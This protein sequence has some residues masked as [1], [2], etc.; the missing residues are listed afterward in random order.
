MHNTG[1]QDRALEDFLSA[2]VLSI[3]IFALLVSLGIIIGGLYFIFDN[4]P[5][6]SGLVPEFF[7]STLD[8]VRNKIESY[9]FLGFLFEHKF[10]EYILRILVFMGAGAMLYYTLFVVY[11]IIIALFVPIFV[12][13]VQ[14]KYYPQVNL[15]SMGLVRI[16]FFY[17]KTAIITLLLFTVLIPAYLIPG[18]NLIVFLPTYYWFHKTI[19][20]DVSAE[21]NTPEEYK[22]IKKT[23]WGELK[24]HTIFCFLL[25]HIPLVGIL[26]YPYYIFYVTH[27]MLNE[28]QAYRYEKGFH[29]IGS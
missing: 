27:Y 16:I 15:R 14:K 10:L 2:K 7:S 9:P 6:I 3:S 17:I 18:L 25:A 24:S 5:S 1:T 12:K 13:D 28:T 29:A 26:L 23:K 21:I 19:V 20:F 22:S 4:T 11:G 8:I